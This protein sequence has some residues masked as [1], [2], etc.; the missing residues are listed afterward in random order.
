MSNEPDA[1]WAA[2]EAGG[3][4]QR[5][6]LMESEEQ[7][8][9]AAFRAGQAYTDGLVAAL[10]EARGVFQHYGDL[11]AAKPDPVKAQRNYDLAA[12]MTAALTAAKGA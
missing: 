3:E 8:C 12:K 6:H 10:E 7:L 1:M 4:I 2:I 5:Q 11:H 9:E